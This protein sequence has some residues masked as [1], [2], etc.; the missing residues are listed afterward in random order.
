MKTN[1]ADVPTVP[2]IFD[3]GPDLANRPLSETMDQGPQ[4]GPA[5]RSVWTW[6]V[7]IALGIVEGGVMLMLE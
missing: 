4:N 1:K 7:I 2:Q 5:G 3:V 6:I